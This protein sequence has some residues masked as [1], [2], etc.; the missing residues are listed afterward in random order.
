MGGSITVTSEPGR[1]S[2][3][4]LELSF[5]VSQSKRE[6]CLYSTANFKDLSVLIVDDDRTSLE[7]MRK[8]VSGFGCKV[9]LA[10]NASEALLQYK[11]ALKARRK[12]D[13]VLLDSRL[14]DQE[15][16]MIAH[17]MQKME[18]GNKDNILLLETAHG[19]ERLLEQ[20]DDTLDYDFLIKPVTPSSLFDTLVKYTDQTDM[21]SQQLDEIWDGNTTNDK[22]IL[23]QK[24][25][26]LAEDNILNQKVAALILEGAGAEVVVANTGKE[27][28]DILSEDRNFDA[29]L[30]DVQMPV[31]DGLA[32]VREIRETLRLRDLPII[33]LTANASKEDRERCLRV[34]MDAYSSK[35]FKP[36]QLF[37]VI[38]EAV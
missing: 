23:A 6:Y 34:G 26:L 17:R 31:M 25:I 38:Q 5:E 27:A 28:V 20:Q 37:D 10:E 29:V 12:F 21:T 15:V 1:G 32:A 19:A 9:T 30:M 11:F 33:A 4:K 36:E 3:F 22:S 7:A 24:R 8:I 14:Q 2:I 13:V 35:P 18:Y 16:R